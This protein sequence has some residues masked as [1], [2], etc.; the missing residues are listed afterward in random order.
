MENDPK[1]ESKVSW[2]EEINQF[3]QKRKLNYS[4]LQNRQ[5]SNRPYLGS[6]K[7]NRLKNSAK[8]SA[9]KF[10]LLDAI[11]IESNNFYFYEK[12]LFLKK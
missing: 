9:L 4:K 2:Y 6:L 10:G 8:R 1:N 11:S 5:K 12:N 3:Q 7:S